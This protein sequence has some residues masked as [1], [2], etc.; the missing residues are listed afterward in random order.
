MASTRNEVASETVHTVEVNVP[1][2]GS[3]CDRILTDDEMRM[4]KKLL[5][6][7]PAGADTDYILAGF[8][9]FMACE[10]L[11][12]DGVDSL[13]QAA[14]LGANYALTM[15]RNATLDEWPED[16]SPAGFI[17][18]FVE[19]WLDHMDDE[20][21]GRRTMAGMSIREYLRSEG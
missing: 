13:E 20:T 21:H 14:F 12:G 4:L 11:R 5:A 6:S 8:A 10:I 7:G 18:G 19:E 17:Y 9:S 15:R 2:M 16:S 3:E 1:A